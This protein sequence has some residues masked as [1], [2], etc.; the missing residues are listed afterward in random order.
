MFPMW[1]FRYCKTL[2]IWKYARQQ[3]VESLDDMKHPWRRNVSNTFWR[4]RFSKLNYLSLRFKY[5]INRLYHRRH[6]IWNEWKF[7]LLRWIFRLD[8]RKLLRDKSNDLIFT[9]ILF[10]LFIS[11]KKKNKIHLFFEF[12][13]M[14]FDSIR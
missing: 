9:I 6:Q 1:N 8:Q 7:H 2:S 14:F 10:L 3:E 5:E 12:F 13:I 11:R 4:S